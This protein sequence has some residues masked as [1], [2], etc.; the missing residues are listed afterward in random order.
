MTLKKFLLFH[1]SRM[2]KCF[3]L[4][5]FEIYLVGKTKSVSGM[6]VLV[7]YEY[8]SA[9]IRYGKKMEILWKH[10]EKN[11]ILTYLCHEISH[12]LT[13]AMTDGITVSK[14]LQKADEQTTEHISRLLLRLYLSKEK[15]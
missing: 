5:H 12:L 14:A 15:K 10:K 13:G 3:N 4:N 11:E 1:S 2:L 7:D 6:D 9:T 8:L